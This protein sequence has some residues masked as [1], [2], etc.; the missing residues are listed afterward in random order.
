MQNL[1]IV[2]N[3]NCLWL[4]KNQFVTRNYSKISETHDQNRSYVDTTYIWDN[5][6]N[7]ELLLVYTNIK[8]LRDGGTKWFYFKMVL[9]LKW[10][11]SLFFKI[12]QKSR[13]TIWP[14]S[15]STRSRGDVYFAG[16]WD[17]RY[18]SPWGKIFQSDQ[19]CSCVT[20]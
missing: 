3:Y 7:F 13:G 4:T 8:E 20:S 19:S 17:L 12:T 15:F 14:G 6:I 1:K 11:I 2:A 5:V 9:I 18:F 10:K 16:I